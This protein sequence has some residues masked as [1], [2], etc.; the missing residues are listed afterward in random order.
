VSTGPDGE[1]GA[2]DAGFTGASGDGTRAFFVTDE[3]LVTADSVVGERSRIAPR[4]GIDLQEM[5][6]VKSRY[7]CDGLAPVAVLQVGWGL[8]GVDP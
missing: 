3:S 4:V 6:D 1:S 8:R 2:F 7:P 5:C